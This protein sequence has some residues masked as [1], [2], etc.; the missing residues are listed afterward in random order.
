MKVTCIF[1]LLLALE[2]FFKYN[3]STIH[4]IYIYNMKIGNYGVKQIWK[5]LCKYEHKY[6]NLKYYFWQIT[7]LGKT[8]NT[9]ALLLMITF[10]FLSTFGIFAAL[11]LLF[12]VEGLS[13][14]VTFLLL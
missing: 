6:H 12:G 7:D 4:K 2:S 5:I 11:S 9:I 1:D 10:L 3:L 13:A 14:N 8:G